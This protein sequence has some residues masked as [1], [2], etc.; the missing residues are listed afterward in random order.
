[1]GLYPIDDDITNSREMREAFASGRDIKVFQ[2]DPCGFKEPSG[3]FFPQRVSAGI[4]GAGTHCV[5]LPR[6]PKPHQFYLT[7]DVD[8]NNSVTAIH[9]GGKPRS[10]DWWRAKLD[11]QAAK[12]KN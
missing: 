6:Y 7:V 2:F 4:A 3:L 12:R 11:K 8:A 10:R 1:M 9:D 5:E